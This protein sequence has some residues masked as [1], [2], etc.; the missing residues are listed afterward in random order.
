ML[1]RPDGARRESRRETRRTRRTH[2]PPSRSL[3]A[4]LADRLDPQTEAT[5]ANWA[6][7]AETSGT[8]RDRAPDRARSRQIARCAQSRRCL[9]QVL[10]REIDFSNER[11]SAQDFERNFANMRTVKVRTTAFPSWRLGAPASLSNPCDHPRLIRLQVPRMHTEL[12]T[13]KIITMEYCPGT[14]ISD[15]DGL[16]AKGFDPDHVSTLLTNSYLEQAGRDLAEI[17]PR[18][19]RDHMR[20]GW[21]R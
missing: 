5:E 15:I 10:Y 3:V 11:R 20:D 6:G 14:K 8:V 2:P 17:W 9:S 7:I 21:P 13:S 4:A 16:R 12:C 18:S 19:G 1:W